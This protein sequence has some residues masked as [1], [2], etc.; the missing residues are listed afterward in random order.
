[1]LYSII[2]IIAFQA[3]FLL[4]YDLF[5]RKETFFNYNRAYLLLTSILSLA[6]PFIKLPELQKM[7]SN[8]MVIQLPEVFIGVETPTAY[9]VSIAEQAGI[10]LEQSTTPIWQMIAFVGITIAALVFLI[11]IARL[12]W[13]KSSNPK[14][15]YSDVLVVRLIKSS[16]AFSFFNTI[17]LGDEIPET[18]KTTIYNHELVHVKEWH[19]LDLLFFELL[20]IILWFNPLV[21]IYQNRTKELHEFIADAKAVKQNG[22]SEY[23]QSLLNQVFDVNH[24]SFTN[25]FFKTSL[26]K[27]RIAMLQK[28]RSKQMNL[29]KYMF[30]IPLLFGM[31]VYTSTEVKAQQ[32]KENVD[33][34]QFSYSMSIG[35]SLTGVKEETHKRYEEFLKS[36]KAYVGWGVLNRETKVVS[37]SVH[38]KGE[39]LPEGYEE[40]EV[41]FPDGQSYKVYMN[42]S[43]FDEA[44]DM[45]NEH[46]D[47]KQ[48]SYS[49][50]SGESLEGNKAEIHKRYEE[51]L[52]S[53]K[54]YVSWA[55]IDH[56]KD[57]IHYSVHHKDEVV[58]EGYTRLGYR[59]SDG[60]TYISYINIKDTKNKN[61]SEVGY[62]YKDEHIEVPFSVIENAPTLPDC[63]GLT[64]KEERKK[65]LS[66]FIQRHINK[67][68]NT[69]IADALKL[70]GKQRIFVSFK[71][72]REGLVQQVKAR[73]S[74]VELEDE[75]IRVVNLLP[76]FIP[77]TQKGKPVV[78]PYSLPIVFQIADKTKEQLTK[79]YNELVAQR[80][81]VLQ[82]SSKDNPVVVNLNK[83]I[84]ALKK[85]IKEKTVSI[86]ENISLEPT[87]RVKALIEEIERDSTKQGKIP[88]SIIQTSPVHPD[89]KSL[90]KKEDRK[91][92]TTNEILK[93]VNRSFNKDLPETLNLPEGRQQIFASFEIDKNGILNDIKVRSPHS[94]LDE[95]TKRVLD[96]LPQFVPGEHKG[97]KVDVIY[98]LPI[99]FQVHETKK[100]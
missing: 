20:R 56:D 60:R 27:K 18:E 89:C 4:V 44:A 73:G 37:Y 41:S 52:T 100:D 68:F 3:L 42:F 40:A 94:K 25:T 84:D 26:I 46:I 1:M 29:F 67:N 95:E 90:S 97:K 9:D 63:E 78:V 24:I 11:K 8:D 5:L 61:I 70:N 99:T 31:L 98:S 7:T 35:E 71:I 47:L 69:A 34:K 64:T 43:Y 85:K 17:F 58:P 77:G 72:D 96:L 48:F 39:V 53:N 82:N 14:R 75:A 92:C 62:S 87:K 15:W 54:D 74:Q 66:R 28:S 51:F 45:E 33:L 22:K 38:H 76:Q 19:S 6:L 13:I 81:R 88:F 21:Y 30:L 36:N 32:N 57:D 16:T 80:D 79:S 49:L 23:Y 2:Q 50:S 59:L 93:F 65:C 12:Y 55:R 86:S 91:K 83:Q 10:I